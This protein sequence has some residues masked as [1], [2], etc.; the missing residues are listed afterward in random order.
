MTF[1]V[2]TLFIRSNHRDKTRVQ[3]PA[4]IFPHLKLKCQLFMGPTLGFDTKQ[5]NSFFDQIWCFI[6][7]KNKILTILFIVKYE[8][9]TLESRVFSVVGA[10]NQ[11][12]FCM[13]K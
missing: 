13:F 1:G 10:H 12:V 5:R 2:I 7:N 8:K 3:M 9:I 11:Q 6:Y 4:K